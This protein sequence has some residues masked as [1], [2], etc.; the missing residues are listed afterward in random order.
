M[1]ITKKIKKRILLAVAVAA[2]VSLIHMIWVRA[3]AAG[4]NLVT[5]NSG[6]GWHVATMYNASVV[7]FVIFAAILGGW[8][9]VNFLKNKKYSD[10]SKK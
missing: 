6:T 9:C 4:Y 7:I 3:S 5:L 1:R 8:L 2:L 10:N